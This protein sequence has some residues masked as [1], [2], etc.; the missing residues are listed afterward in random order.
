MHIEQNQRKMLKK[1]LSTNCEINK[2]NENKK[3]RIE[4]GENV[5]L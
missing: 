1:L 5:N 4:K 3:L 2:T